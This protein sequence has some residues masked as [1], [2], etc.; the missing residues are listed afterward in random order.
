MTNRPRLALSFLA[1]LAF[2]ALPVLFAQTGE[3]AKPAVGAAPAATP[4]PAAP[5]GPQPAIVAVEAVID[6][7]KVAKGDPVEA[8]FV[9]RNDGEADL[10][11]NDVR[12]T[13]G[14]TVASY[15]G[16]IAPGKTGKVHASVATKDFAGPIAKAITVLSN[17]PKTPRLTL[18]VKADV[19]VLVEVRPGYARYTFVQNQEPET[20][21]QFVWAKDDPSFAVTGV[22]TKN[23]AVKAT[24][25]KANPDE[26]QKDANAGENQWIVETTLLPSVETG[27]LRDFLEIRTNHKK[28][29]KLEIPVTGFVR[30]LLAVTPFVADFGSVS[31]AQGPKDVSVILNNFGKEPVEIRK[32]STGVAGVEVTWKTLD[33][34]KRFEIKLALTPAMAKG[35]VDAKLHIETSSAVVPTLDVPL[36]GA[37]S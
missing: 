9:L 15:D 7:G 13:C 11:L 30:P 6:A 2:G 31:L 26:L 8:V 22:E 12:P 25:R 3:A 23:P 5:V 35:T 18:T 20:L 21:R 28:Q 36:R 10:V 34:G 4:P 19:Q 29:P 14:C 27:A 17:D 37:V 24:F 32:V 33:A 1:V 16:K